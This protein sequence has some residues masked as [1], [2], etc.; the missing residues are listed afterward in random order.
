LLYLQLIAAAGSVKASTV[1]YI[2]PVVALALGW[3]ILDEAISL[4]I[5]AGVL[6]ILAGVIGVVSPTVAS[7]PRVAARMKIGKR[8]PAV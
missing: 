7:D 6:L 5:V 1:T 4:G 3:L 8:A 2:I